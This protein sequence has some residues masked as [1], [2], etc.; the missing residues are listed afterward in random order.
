M[1]H[2][3]WRELYARL[4]LATIPLRPR[5]K[6]P[7]RKGWLAAGPEQWV[8]A[9][10]DANIGILTGARS[11]GLAVLDFDTPDGPERVLGMTPEQL[12]V[13]TLVVRTARGWHVYAREHGCPTRTIRAGVD[14]RGEGGMVV[15][16]P[17]VHPSG[18][19]YEIVRPAASLVALGA[20]L[21]RDAEVVDAGASPSARRAEAE[22]WIALQ[23]PRLREHWRRLTEPPSASFNA[24]IA[25]FAVART[26]W[27]AGW[28]AE[29]VVALLLALPGSRAA[30]RGEAYARRTVERAFSMPPR[31]R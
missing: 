11:N 16:P 12:S 25:D 17:S 28:P 24:S 4:G 8:G 9:P 18:C 26:L 15:A 20:L 30:G 27:E 14:L 21:P 10:A 23:A 7:L 2:D 29:D 5:A 13:I 1:V 3:E 6:R 22:E 19:R 31:R